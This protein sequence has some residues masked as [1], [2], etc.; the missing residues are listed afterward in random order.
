M[1]KQSLPPKMRVWLFMWKGRTKKKQNTHTKNNRSHT[2]LY[3]LENKNKAN[4]RLFDEYFVRDEHAHV[5][6]FFL[7]RTMKPEK[8]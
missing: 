7:R 3:M 5:T 1:A 6:I 2:S 8:G 4:W